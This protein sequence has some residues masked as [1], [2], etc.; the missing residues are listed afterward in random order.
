MQ[1][2]IFSKNKHRFVNYKKLNFYFLFINFVF[3]SFYCDD[4][5]KRFYQLIR[6]LRD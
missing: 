2:L 3:Y 6:Y 4:L 5:Q 1:K